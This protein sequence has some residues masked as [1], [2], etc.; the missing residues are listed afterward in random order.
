MPE[1]HSLSFLYVPTDILVA[2]DYRPYR[3]FLQPYHHLVRMLHI[4]SISAFF[5][6]IVLLDLRLAGFR[7]AVALKDLSGAVM[8]WIYATFA[9]GTVTG[10]MLFFYDPVHVASHAYFSLKIILIVLG[11]ANAA[12]FNQRG[13]AAAI[14]SAGPMPRR[15]RIFGAISLAVW[16]GAMICATLNV[17]AAPKVL[18]R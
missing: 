13:F 4:L 10:V 3:F 15:A 9:I 11:M 12:V 17:E 5:G 14:N 8:S 7:T 2:L 6:A 18:L 1:P 16:T